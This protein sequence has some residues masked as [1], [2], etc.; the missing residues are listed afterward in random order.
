MG[1]MT[2]SEMHIVGIVKANL[3][4]KRAYLH[5]GKGA[6]LRKQG[7]RR[8]HLGIP[9]EGFLQLSN[10]YICNS[11][12]FLLTQSRALIILKASTMFSR[13]TTEGTDI[14]LSCFG[15]IENHKS[16]RK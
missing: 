16:R 4:L 7:W 14:E 13:Q 6:P 2:L 11:I 10:G 3:E 15:I 1:K 12:R 8:E 5:W 9:H